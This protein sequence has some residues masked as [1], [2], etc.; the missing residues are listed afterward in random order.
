MTTAS[1]NVKI[2]KDLKESTEILLKSMGL[3]TSSAITIFFKAIN[4]HNAIPFQIKADPF[5]SKENMELLEKSIAQL[6]SGKGQRH[7]LIEV[8]DD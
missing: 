5:Y 7:E 3:T 4:H 2:D 1:I 8:E 6:E